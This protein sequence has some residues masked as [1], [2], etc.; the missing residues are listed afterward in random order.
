MG[1]EVLEVP[2]DFNDSLHICLI[3]LTE[4]GHK[5]HG[6][7]DGL[8]IAPAWYNLPSNLALG[9]KTNQSYYLNGTQ[10]GFRYVE[11]QHVKT[12]IEIGLTA[13]HLIATEAAGKQF[14]K[15]MP[16]TIVQYTDA[17]LYNA[18]QRHIPR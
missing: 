13:T 3:E 1:P 4:D 7:N 17:I 8:S 11:G 16:N 14:R 6:N 10:L 12:C 2:L 15:E 9:L 5:I 18:I